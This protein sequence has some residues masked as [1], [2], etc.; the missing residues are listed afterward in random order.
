MFS[1][2]RR[3]LSSVKKTGWERRRW[4]A[5]GNP[6]I[7]IYMGISREWM[8]QEPEL[9]A[10]SWGYPRFICV[11]FIRSLTSNCGTKRGPQWTQHSAISN[12]V[13]SN[14]LSFITYINIAMFLGNQ[15]FQLK[16]EYG[17]ANLIAREIKDKNRLAQ[18]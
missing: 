2:Y 1:E 7:V 3:A 14:L 8:M 15:S 18:A 11:E 17:K 5:A 9:E 4:S 16:S 12:F 10:V 6:M 13:K